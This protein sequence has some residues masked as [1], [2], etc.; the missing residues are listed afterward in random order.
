MCADG[1]RSHQPGST[2]FEVLGERDGKTKIYSLDHF[3]G[4]PFREGKASSGKKK[5]GGRPREQWR[6]RGLPR[7]LFKG[8]KKGRPAFPF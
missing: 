8:G 6:R 7:A 5:K 1:R 3:G 2:K 4:L